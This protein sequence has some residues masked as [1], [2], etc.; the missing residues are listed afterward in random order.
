MHDA[1]DGFTP[2]FAPLDP[3][4]APGAFQSYLNGV[5][6]QND[7]VSDADAVY[8]PLTD[9]RTAAA[10]GVKDK[11]LRVKDYVSANVAWRKYLN[12]ISTAAD[13]LRGYRLPKKVPTPPAGAVPPP[14]KKVGQGARSQQGYADLENLFGKLIK[15]VEKITGYTAPAGSGLTI[16]E[17]KAQDAAFTQLNDDVSEAEA[18]LSEAQ[19][20]RK[21]FYD[22]E[23]GLKEKMKCIKKA[24]RSQYGSASPQYAAVNAIKL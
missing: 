17:I 1:I 4:L 19:R 6:A 24:V 18:T 16:A 23:N 10:L 22:G 21:D 13:N 14:P 5:E 20:V 9:A 11:A 7:A 2:A 12:A 15:Q 3:N 8:S